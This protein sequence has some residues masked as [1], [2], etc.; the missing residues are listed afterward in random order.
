MHLIS[1]AR[2]ITSVVQGLCVQTTSQ[3]FLSY[4]LLYLGLRSWSPTLTTVETLLENGFSAERFQPLTPKKDFTHPLSNP[5]YIKRPLFTRVG[6]FPAFMPYS[7]QVR[8]NKTRTCNTHRY[9][10][11]I[12]SVIQN[13]YLGFL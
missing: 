11:A 8:K 2:A 13:T 9:L 3:P 12:T 10:I 1:R 6:K 7:T 4:H 5:Q